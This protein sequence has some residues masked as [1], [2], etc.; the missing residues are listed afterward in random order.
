MR[1][2]SRLA[3]ASPTRIYDGPDTHAGGL[4]LGCALA[5][6]RRRGVRIPQLLGWVGL[7]TLVGCS[8][9]A[10]TTSSVAYVI[11][12]I[13]IAATVFVGSAL[14]PGLLGRCFSC[15]PLVWL[16]AIS[17]SLYLWHSVVFWLLNWRNPVVALPITLGVAALS[18]YKIERP[19]RASFRAKSEERGKAQP[20]LAHVHSRRRAE[21][22]RPPT[23]APKGV[24]AML[25]SE[26]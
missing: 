15:R 7:V 3:G 10:P 9:L 12:L 22:G 5:V 4:L 2:G 1:P 13:A 14:E 24:F 11:P 16:G 20:A 21:D 18:Y 8:V 17:Y 19:L 23:W 26:R 25:F 6:L